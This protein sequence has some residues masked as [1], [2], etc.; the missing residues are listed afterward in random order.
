MITIDGGRCHQSLAARME[1]S[2]AFDPSK[3]YGTWKEEI[4]E[5]FLELVGIPFIEENACPLKM[6]IESDEMMDGY[7]QIQVRFVKTKFAKTRVKITGLLLFFDRCL[8]LTS[9]QA[10]YRQ[11]NI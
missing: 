6:E 9:V 3:D 7:R 4:R 10:L 11:K 5:K 2:L 1:Q 8:G